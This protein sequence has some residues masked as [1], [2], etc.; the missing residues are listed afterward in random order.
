MLLVK[1]TKRYP[2]SFMS[3]LDVLRSFLRG[4]VRAGIKIKRSE[5]FNP[6]ALVY[7]TPPL[8]L[9][10]GSDAEYMCIETEMTAEEFCQKFKNQTVKGIDIV[11]A[12]NLTKN[13]NVAGIVTYSDYFVEV[14]L[15][16]KQK[17]IIN[18]V[19]ASESVVIEYTQKDKIVQ[20]EVRDCIALME[21]KEN[22][23][24]LRLT[25]GNNNLRVDRLLNGIKDLNLDFNIYDVIRKEQYT[26]ELDKL[27]PLYSLE[28]Y[29]K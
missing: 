9:S 15:N 29:E 20:K 7:F 25:S 24:F 18:N 28:D 3:H 4:F 11:S 13:P 6:H 27:I 19:M 5:G 2:A 26:G 16:D 17:E 22:G 1:F 23:L 21:C 12:H 14:S 8:P 10:V